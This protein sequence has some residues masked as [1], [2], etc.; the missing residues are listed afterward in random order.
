M[1]VRA[2]LFDDV[3]TVGRLIASCFGNH[4]LAGCICQFAVRA[5][6]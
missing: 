5:F 6:P 1:D 4:G 2:A 3:L